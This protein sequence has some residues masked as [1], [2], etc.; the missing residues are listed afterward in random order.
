MKGV[1]AQAWR[2]RAGLGLLEQ[3]DVL[4][5]RGVFLPGRPFVTTP[6]AF[7]RVLI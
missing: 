4:Y 1:P 3:T 7:V 6:N 5:Q 2:T